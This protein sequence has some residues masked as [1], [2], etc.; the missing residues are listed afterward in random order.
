MSL[1]RWWTSITNSTNLIDP[2]YA[3]ARVVKVK[4]SHANL[5]DN[6]ASL[7]KGN[8]CLLVKDRRS[9]PLLLDDW[10]TSLKLLIR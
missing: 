4:S 3:I 6:R 9:H 5:L 1:N 10:K 2:L 8:S 7:G